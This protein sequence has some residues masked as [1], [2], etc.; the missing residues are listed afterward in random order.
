[1]EHIITAENTTVTEAIRSHVEKR[2]AKFEKYAPADTTVY[3]KLEVKNNGDRHKVEVTIHFGK[4][5][6]RAEVNDTNMYA[7]IDTVEK[8]MSRLLRKRKEKLVEKSQ[9]P[10]DIP[11][12]EPMIIHEYSI[13]KRKVHPLA[14]MNEQEACEAMEMVGHPFYVYF[15]VDEDKTCAVYMRS[16][17]T[18]GK[19]IYT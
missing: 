6:L 5:T 4:Q 1:M 19:L 13:A 12:N 9:K 18:Y 2:F 11:T 15:D 8:T 10:A 14:I 7:A 3:T 17:K 16:D